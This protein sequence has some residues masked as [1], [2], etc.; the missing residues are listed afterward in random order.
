M[1]L[2]S[3]GLSVSTIHC[4]TQVASFR[5]VNLSTGAAGSR[6]VHAAVPTTMLL[7]SPNPKATGNSAAG[8]H[9]RPPVPSTPTRCQFLRTSDEGW[10]CCGEVE[11]WWAKVLTVYE[12]LALDQAL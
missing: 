5:Y 2:A 12:L 11:T 1:I 3:V 9:G 7:C 10:R 8:A 6:S 4:S